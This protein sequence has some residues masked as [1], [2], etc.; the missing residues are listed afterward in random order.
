[1]DVFTDKTA[2]HDWRDTLNGV[3]R[4]FYSPLASDDDKMV[5]FP[6]KYVNDALSQNILYYSY[7]KP[8]KIELII[9]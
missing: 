2:P 7:E 6:S 9:F 3:S 5:P 4:Q 8:A 1:M